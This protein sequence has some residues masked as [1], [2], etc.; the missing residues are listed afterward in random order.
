MAMLVAL[1]RIEFANQ[2]DLKNSESNLT[3]VSV[4]IIILLLL[5]LLLNYFHFIIIYCMH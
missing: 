3:F 2:S 5:L 1:E 4:I